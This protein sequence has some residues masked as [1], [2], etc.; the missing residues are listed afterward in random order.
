[1]SLQGDELLQDRYRIVRR[2]QQGGMGAVYEAC[3]TKLANS[4]CAVKKILDAAPQGRDTDFM[5]E[6]LEL[7]MKSLSALDH[8]SIPK[9]RD[10]FTQDA[11][12]YLVMELIQGA[13]LEEEI[14]RSLRQSGLPP[15]PEQSVRDIVSLLD[16]VAYLHAQQPP[17]IHRDI[18]PANILRDEKTGSIKLVDFG[19]ARALDTTHN[20]TLVGTLGYCS[21]EQMMGKACQQS[22]LYSVAV[23]LTQLLTGR[24]PETLNFEPLHPDLPGVRPGLPEIIQRATQ[25]KPADRYPRA[26]EMSQDLRAWLEG[27]P[28]QTCVSAPTALSRPRPWAKVAAAM[29]A[30]GTALAVGKTLG[31]APAPPTPAA[32]PAPLAQ[33]APLPPPRPIAP[34]RTAPQPPATRLPEPKTVV[35]YVYVPQPQPAPPPLSPSPA[36]QKIVPSLGETPGYPVRDQPVAHRLPPD[37]PPPS[38]DPWAQPLPPRQPGTL[39]QE[40]FQ[41][42]SRLQRWRNAHRRKPRKPD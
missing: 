8:P 11:T 13:S 39:S 34:P 41:S 37:P 1:M 21:P 17:V 26:Q 10:Y 35:K 2:I 20:Q 16:T 5:M 30:L 25:L 29:L 32:V 4:P 31:Q 18:K 3:D 23:T 7:E 15:D 36:A 12:V 9:V 14:E 22:D 42:K 24:A 33:K 27:L 19:L 40:P 28:I 38:Q 6:R